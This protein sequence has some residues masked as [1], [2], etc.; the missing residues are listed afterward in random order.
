LT[1]ATRPAYR[2][3]GDEGPRVV[4]WY[5]E[6]IEETGR[7][8]V[9]WMLIAFVVTFAATRFVTRR[10]RARP[11]PGD[12]DEPG[13]IGDIHIGGVH[14]HHQ[15]WGIL[16]ILTSALLE[17]AYQ[18]DTPWLEVLGALF[19]VGAALTLDEF[20]LW[21]HLD[22]VYWSEEGRK[23]IDA[24]VI[25]ACLGGVLLLGT[26]PFGVDD[27]VSGDGLA[28]AA[29]TVAFAIALSMVALLKGKTLSGIVGL[30]LPFISLIAAIRLAKPESP[31]ARWRYRSRPRKMERS[32][33]RFGAE[34]QQRLDRLRDL[35]GGAPAPRQP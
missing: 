6:T 31:W 1:A 27:N 29:T 4:E 25:A 30:F 34:R 21:L 19:G 24:V 8:G 14:V 15:V 26:A 23:S 13:L 28:A 3:R 5:R 10:I 20:A 7:S 35:V 18:P 17:F 32:E 16:L 2:R 11:A 12:S 9:L 22:D 33:R